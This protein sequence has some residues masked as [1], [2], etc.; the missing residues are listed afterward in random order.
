MSISDLQAALSRNGVDARSTFSKADLISK[1]RVHCAPQMMAEMAAKRGAPAYTS[2]PATS[3][4]AGNRREKAREAFHLYTLE[5][6]S[7]RS[8]SSLTPI[9]EHHD[10]IAKPAAL[11]ALSDLLSDRMEART[12]HD[13]AAVLFDTYDNGRIGVIGLEA[14][15]GIHDRLL[16][17]AR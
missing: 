10:K 4:A 13:T 9:L 15:L 11:M 2:A 1:V 16:E 7:P 6:G 12:L 8:S 17:M 3:P 14:F 5:T